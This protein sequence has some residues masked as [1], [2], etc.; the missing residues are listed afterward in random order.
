MSTLK[1]FTG[2]AHLSSIHINLILFCD[3]FEC[4]CKVPDL[5][6]VESVCVQFE[7][8]GRSRE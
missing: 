5:I 2:H 6:P 8:S 4:V 3:L 7:F 1:L